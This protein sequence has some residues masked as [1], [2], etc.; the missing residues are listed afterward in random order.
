MVVTG[1][2]LKHLLSVTKHG[3][4]GLA[5]DSLKISQPALSKSI[6][7]FE[8]AL[9]VKL[10]DRSR[11][12]VVLTVFGEL[13]LQHGN[14]ILHEQ[15]QLLR[16][17]KL[18]A[19][20]DIGV[21][22]VS[23]GPYPSVVSGYAAAARMLTLHPNL[24]LSLHV[25]DWRNVIDVVLAEQSDFGVAEI[26]GWETDHRLA[27]ELLGEHRARVF[28]RPG[29]PLLGKGPRTLEHLCAFPWAATRLPKRVADHFPPGNHPAGHIDPLNG[30]FVPA[31]E[32][33]VPMRLGQFTAGTDVLVLA[34]L[35]LLEKELEAGEVVPVPGFTTFSRY[36]FVHLQTRS[37]SPAAQA[38]M[39]EIRAVE[40]E[41]VA[42]EESLAVRYR[43][44]LGIG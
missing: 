24:R 9:G 7:G 29:H 21:A 19:N 16:E 34:N 5:A 4:F 25:E 30:D 26:G 39:D 6:L 20:L 11:S 27:T 43:T 22:R 23:F 28:C 32:L 36:G 12:G 41:F 33:N 17:I 15:A 18:L 37:I 44:E 2:R 3:H 35:A 31:I 8:T 10:L 13:V 40:A 1:T 42:R 38:F 14:A